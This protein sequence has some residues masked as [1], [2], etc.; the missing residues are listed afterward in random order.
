MKKTLIAL[1]LSSLAFATS[2]S[3]AHAQSG[4]ADQRLVQ[5]EPKVIEWRRHLH[6]NPELGNREFETAKYITAHLKSLGM[7][8][9]TGVA[10]T[11]VVALLKGGKPGPTVALRADMDALPVTEQVDIPFASKAKTEYNGEQ[12]G[13]MHAC[14]HD[15]H[16]AM[17][18]GA[19]QVLSDMRD[20]LA[21]N[22]LFIFQPAEE[23]APDGEEGG[24]ELM[25]KEGLFKKYKPDVAFGQHVT[26]SLPVGV[27]G[28]RS[29]PLMAS[30]DEFRINVKG[31]QTHGSRPWGGVDP[32]TA[33]AQIVMG[34]QTLVSRQIDITKEPAVVSYG[35]IDGGVR[36]NIIPDSVY[37]NGTIRN[38]DMDNRQEIFKRLKVTAEKIAESSGATAEVEILEGYPVT[39]NNPELTA[40]AISTLKAAAGDKNVM[41]IPKITGAEDFSFFANEIPGFYYFLGVTPKGTNPATAPSNHSPRFYVDESALAVGTRTLTQ[42]T[43]DYFASQKKQ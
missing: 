6:Q 20:E 10:H 9:E 21:G 41:V 34:T 43:L 18:M 3:T 13:V 19:A 16:V 29:G 35:V 15:T 24:A 1:S 38:F 28:Y 14:G 8:V 7:E 37:L 31:R 42:L 27:I 4:D 26:S 22:V 39:V 11:G 32:I 2:I 36:N 40:A 23:G 33:A 5:A 30:S 12:V 25:L 17:L